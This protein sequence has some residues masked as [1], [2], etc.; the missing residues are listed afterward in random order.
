MVSKKNKNSKTSKIRVFF[1]V[2]TLLL[3][4]AGILGW[5]LYRN[6]DNPINTSSNYTSGKP[7][8]AETTEQTNIESSHPEESENNNE[9]R[10]PSTQVS[11]EGSLTDNQGTIQ[12]IPDENLW[13]TSP[14]NV[15]ALYNPQYNSILK[16]GDLV[17]GK[18]TSNLVSFRLIDSVSGVIAQGEISVVNGNFSGSLNFNTTADEGRVDVFTLNPDGTES[19]NLEVPVRFR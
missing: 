9:S 17:Q 12:E 7:E 6:S 3:L 19:N 13:I 8:F 5:I 16:S 14:G 18:S 15:I 10:T 4:T 2:T 11:N 1:L